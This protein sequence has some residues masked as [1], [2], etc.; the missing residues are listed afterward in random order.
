M[1]HPTNNLWLK[2]RSRAC[3]AAAALL[4]VPCVQIDPNVPVNHK[5]HLDFILHLANIL[6]PRSYLELGIFH[7][8]LFNQMIPYADSLIGVDLD[9]KAG[10]FMAPSPKA[11]FVS[12]RTDDFAEELRRAP[13]TFDMIFIDADHS[14]EA[15]EADF[16]NFLPFLAPHGLLLLHDTHPVDQAA[17]E[18]ERCDDGY[19]AIDALSRQSDDWEMITIP[20]HPGLT[21]CRKRTTQLKWQ[22][23]V[24]KP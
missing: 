21:L 24:P 16:R 23:P 17:T 19:V 6:R 8:G 1:S 11:R 10:T 22:E 5:W 7:C 20:V 14:K 9:P 2:L 4:N 3:S 15:V 13:Q 18:R 12:A